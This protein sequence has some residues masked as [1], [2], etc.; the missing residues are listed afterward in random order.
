MTTLAKDTPRDQVLGN[1]N[2]FAVIASDIIYEGSAVGLVDASGHARPLTSADKFVGFAIEKADN[3]LGSAADINV[4]VNKS[5]TVKLSVSGAVITDIGQPI[6]ATDD[7]A[8][9]FSPVSAVFIGFVKRFVSSGVV[10]VEFDAGVMVD[11]W[12]DFVCEALAGD[13]TLDIQDTGKAIFQS[14]DAKTVTLLTYAAATALDVVIVN[15]GAFGTVETA[16]DPAAGDKISGPN[17]TGADGG[18]ATNT[19]ATARRGDFI[20]LQ[21]GGDDGYIV[22]KMKGTWTI[23]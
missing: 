11:P 23:A 20:H 6:Y 14:T 7:N 9:Q 18:I 16:V 19:K 13:L 17:D 4:N 2:S 10:E 12:A 5:G 22:K 21:S 15:I 8:F 3:S 1:V